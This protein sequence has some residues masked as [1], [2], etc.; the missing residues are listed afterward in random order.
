MKQEDIVATFADTGPAPF[1]VECC[2]CAAPVYTA[3]VGCWQE[4]VAVVEMIEVGVSRTDADGARS[5]AR[6]SP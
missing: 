2:G 1:E 3:P 5:A 6:R 4:G